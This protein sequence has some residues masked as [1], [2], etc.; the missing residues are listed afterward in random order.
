MARG[1]AIR[2]VAAR[3][4]HWLV[5]LGLA[6][7]WRFCRGALNNPSA[8]SAMWTGNSWL[9]LGVLAA[10]AILAAAVQH[11]VRHSVL[12]A[13]FQVAA[14]PLRRL[15]RLHARR[16]S[17]FWPPASHW[18]L[19][20]SNSP[21]RPTR[22]VPQKTF[23]AARSLGC[24]RCRCCLALWRIGRSTYRSCISCSPGVRLHSAGDTSYVS[25]PDRAATR[26]RTRN[27]DRGA[28]RSLVRLAAARLLRCA[29]RAPLRRFGNAPR[30]C[31][32]FGAVRLL[33]FRCQ[34]VRVGRAADGRQL[35]PWLGLR[36]RRRIRRKAASTPSSW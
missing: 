4:S 14:L 3:S 24:R 8:L 28:H 19:A 33:A 22:R 13:L 1:S 16:R 30:H 25:L 32:R 26:P 21:T 17:S 27:A 35:A 6:V 7:R 11:F 23:S 18:A 20:C 29:T 2:I 9:W 15:D 5:W 34:P 36:A 10:V 12:F 31:A